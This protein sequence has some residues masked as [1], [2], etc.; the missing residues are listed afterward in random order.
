MV[1]TAGGNGTRCYEHSGGKPQTHWA[2]ARQRFRPPPSNMD[3]MCRSRWGE[4]N[5]IQVAHC[6]ATAPEA[7]TNGVGVSGN[8]VRMCHHYLTT[9]LVC[10]HLPSTNALLFL[11]G[12]LH[13]LDQLTD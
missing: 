4:T 7:C 8:I 1:P 9:L 3:S 5:I 11:R 13:L 6:C 12:C 2:I 10:Y